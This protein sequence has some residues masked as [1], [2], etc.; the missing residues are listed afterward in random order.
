MEDGGAAT[1][2]AEEDR[3]CV[4]NLEQ[5]EVERVLG[6]VGGQRWKNALSV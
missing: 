6:E 3:R 1:R 2:K 5:A 4:L